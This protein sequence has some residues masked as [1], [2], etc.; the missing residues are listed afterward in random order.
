MY[1]YDADATLSCYYDP[2]R[3]INELCEDS[4]IEGGKH[5]A[6]EFDECVYCKRKVES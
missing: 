2:P 5:V 6:S 3:P 4:P 1:D